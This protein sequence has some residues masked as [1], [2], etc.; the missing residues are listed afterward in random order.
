MQY[1]DCPK[2]KRASFL[3][4]TSAQAPLLR[5]TVPRTGTPVAQIGTPVAQTGTPV[6]QTG[7]TVPQTGTTRR[8]RHPKAKM[9]GQET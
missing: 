9:S 5:E 3:G 7:T 6:A 8:K 2:C 4:T 1:V